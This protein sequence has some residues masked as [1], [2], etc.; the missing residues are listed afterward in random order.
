MIR[1]AVAVMACWLGV[2]SSTMLLTSC[3]GTPASSPLHDDP[4]RQAP[5]HASHR[6]RIVL[7]DSSAT[8]AVITAGRATIDEDRHMTLLTDGVHVV[9]Y[10]VATGAQTAVLDADN[11]EVND[12]TQDMVA[13]GNVI[14]VS[15]STATTLR[16]PR[17]LWNHAQ[18][19]LQSESTVE[20]T[21]PREQI[22][23]VGFR[24]D[25]YLSDYR[26]YHVRGIRQ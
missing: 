1:P 12:V 10:N 26:I 4:Y 6:V 23:G 22:H 15:D 9:L 16:T 2:V 11:A 20:I 17:V 13:T 19:Q 7:Y 5:L 8:Q 21:T 3:D 18:Q 24:S 25:Q 14:F